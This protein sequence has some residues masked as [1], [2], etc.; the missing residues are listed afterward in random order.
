M[1]V[2]VLVEGARAE[3][4]RLKGLGVEVSELHDQP[5]GKRSF[6]FVVPDGISGPAVRTPP[7]GPH[8]GS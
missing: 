8:S 3:H 2:E 1:H 6:S 5:W 7:P 4:A